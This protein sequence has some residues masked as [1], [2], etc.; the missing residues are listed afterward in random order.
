MAQKLAFKAILIAFF[1]SIPATN[2]YA[3]IIFQD[4]FESQHSLSNSG[5]SYVSEYWQK[6]DSGG[7]GNNGGCAKVTG[8]HPL[9]IAIPNDRLE[10]YIR[11]YAKVTNSSGGQKW[12]KVFGERN[13]STYTNTT[14]SRLYQDG[15]FYSVFYGEGCS[16]CDTQSALPFPGGRW[17]PSSSWTYYEAHIKFAE[18]PNWHNGIVEV[19]YGNDQKLSVTGVNNRNSAHEGL[20][21]SYISISDYSNNPDS[22]VGDMWIDNIVVSDTRIGRIGNNQ[23]YT[24]P[25][26][27]T[28]FTAQAADSEIGLSWTNP[29]DQD[30]QGTLIRYTT[31]DNPYPQNRYDGT[32][33]ADKIAQAG[34]SDNILVTG[35]TNGVKFNFSAFSYDINENYSNT[36]DLS[37]TPQGASSTQIEPP[38]NLR[39]V[40]DN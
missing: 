38:E 7:Y 19:W 35:L 24:P 32:Y 22:Q 3:E 20:N 40:S 37:A 1:V 27:V 2:A 25:S 10:L 13:G 17:F 21:I 31:G 33:V 4:D 28:N 34:S 6:S 5:Y 18:G 30:F 15:Y 39:V 9:H 14:F 29:T 11:F 16:E 8:G 23:D 26:G 12:L 36:V